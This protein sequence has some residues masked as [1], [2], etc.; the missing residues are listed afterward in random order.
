MTKPEI[1][2]TITPQADLVAAYDAAYRRYRA[3]Y[4]AIKDL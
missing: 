3:A 4:P 1:A 2:Y